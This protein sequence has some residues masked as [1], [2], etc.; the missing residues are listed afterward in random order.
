MQPIEQKK[1]RAEKVFENIKIKFKE[2]SNSTISE[3]KMASKKTSRIITNAEKKMEEGLTD[4]EYIQK[5][6]ELNI[7]IMENLKKLET[8]KLAD[9]MIDDLKWM[10]EIK[11]IVLFDIDD[12]VRLAD[13]R[14]PIRDEILKLH[15]QRKEVDKNSELHESMIKRID[16]LWDDFFVAGLN[17]EPRKDMIELCNM[18]YDLGFEVK[19]RT[20]ATAK[21]R[22]ETEN[23]LVSNGAKFHE[24]RMRK[25]GVKIP[26]PILKPAWIPKYD[27]SENVFATYDDQEPVNERYRGKGVVD[28]VLVTKDFDVKQ[29]IKDFK[30][31]IDKALVFIKKEPKELA[32]KRKNKIQYG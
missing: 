2:Y 7:K 18:Y 21:Y 4:K 6:M 16:K 24:L 12:T 27:G 3:E 19:F 30:E 31:K 5:I 15:K 11:F 22:E 9:F 25:E 20:G 8:P 10:N 17:D 13:H 14:M 1:L 29:H 23:Y 26:A 28:T 32:I